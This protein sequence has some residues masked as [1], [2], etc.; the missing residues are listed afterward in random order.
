MSGKLP[1]GNDPYKILGVEKD[2]GLK[3]LKR[4]YVRMIKQFRP[5]QHPE[6][7]QRIQQAYSLLRDGARSVGLQSVEPEPPA[8]EGEA[9]TPSVQH[10]CTEEAEVEAFLR[11]GDGQAAL[12][13][14][15]AVNDGNPDAYWPFLWVERAENMV[16]GGDAPAEKM[17]VWWGRALIHGVD[18]GEL[19]CRSWNQSL[20][21]A[22]YQQGSLQW[23]YLSR[24]SFDEFVFYALQTVVNNQLWEGETGALMSLLQST[25]FQTDLLS[26][27]YLLSLIW[28]VAAFSFQE[29]P[30]LATKLL[31]QYPPAADYWDLNLQRFD[32]FW[33]MRESLP[34][35]AA[36]AQIPE[37]LQRVIRCGGISDRFDR[38]L[39]GQLKHQLYA[40]GDALL[41]G[42]DRVKSGN[43]Q[44]MTHIARTLDNVIPED[45]RMW[46]EL[47]QGERN[48][49]SG[50][51]KDLDGRLESDTL[52]SFTTMVV[53]SSIIFGLGLLLGG[54]W[55]WATVCAGVLV[56]AL[57]VVFWWDNR[58]YQSLIR[59][60]VL[61]QIVE[62]GIPMSR[63]WE[64]V[65]ERKKSD[66]IDRFDD[67]LEGD[68]SLNML[69]TLLR[70]ESE[71]DAGS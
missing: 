57:A 36:D 49:V 13:L 58:L 17:A 18:V 11:N 6:E 61:K 33:S 28:K 26:R 60:F 44:M 51:L 52:N 3:E 42:L 40:Q 14:L 19:I 23:Q 67:D 66:D 43:E 9:D 29:Q 68:D 27:G 32:E 50:L 71:P 5:E 10:Q 20:L 39:V 53:G 38:E 15:V 8:E 70:F 4:A 12:A 48:E 59:P 69:S 21:E 54:Q 46:H 47:E 2:T 34:E 24:Q 64:G 63:F 25:E 65:V 1:D 62:R 45:T 55:L 22:L 37:I 16:A 30:D 31:E 7:F 35:M 56:I 41:E